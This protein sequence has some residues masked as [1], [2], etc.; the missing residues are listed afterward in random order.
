MCDFTTDLFDTQYGIGIFNALS[1]TK[2]TKDPEKCNYKN[3]HLQGGFQCGS[4]FFIGSILI[5]FSY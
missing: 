2:W 3:V 5:G 1:Y 4:V